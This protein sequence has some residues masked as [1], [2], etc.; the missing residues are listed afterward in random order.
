MT[1][2]SRARAARGGVYERCDA[3]MIRGRRAGTPAM[4]AVAVTRLAMVAAVLLIAFGATVDLAWI[5]ASHCQH[6][7]GGHTCENTDAK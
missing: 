4:A 1:P 2:E 6:S 7:L 3:A 5:Q